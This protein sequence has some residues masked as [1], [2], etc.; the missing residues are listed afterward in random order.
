MASAGP[1]GAQDGGG[2]RGA[3]PEALGH[4]RPRSPGPA[5]APTPAPAPGPELREGGPGSRPRT[6]RGGSSRHGE[7]GM[8][9]T[10]GWVGGGGG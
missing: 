4:P 8:R 5:T 3:G 7:P 1:D 9:D 6:A 2:E 10:A